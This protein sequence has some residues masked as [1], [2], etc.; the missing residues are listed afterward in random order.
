M[1][2][3]NQQAVELSHLNIVSYRLDCP[4]CFKVRVYRFESE[5][6]PNTTKC[7]CCD[8]Y[9]VLNYDFH[10]EEEY[11]LVI[12]KCKSCGRHDS[13]NQLYMQDEKCRCGGEVFESIPID[14]N[15]NELT[16]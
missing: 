13:Y 15:G 12:Y 2:K 11:A 4:Y 9:F 1:I 8:S 7:K 6:L 3:L 16:K 5:D 10:D 14:L